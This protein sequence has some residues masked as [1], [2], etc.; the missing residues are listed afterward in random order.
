MTHAADELVALFQQGRYPEAEL[1]ARRWITALPG[2][3]FGWK[4]LGTILLQTGRHGEAIAALEEAAQRMPEDAETLGNLGQAC[5]RLGNLHLAHHRHDEAEACYRRSLGLMPDQPDGW[6]NLGLALQ[7]ANR[8]SEAEAAFRQAMRLNP[9]DPEIHAN[10]YQLLQAQ[11]RLPDA[12]A[13]LREIA[14]LQPEDATLRFELGTRLFLLECHGEAEQAF[15]EAI[16]LHP[17]HAE[18]YN[19]L[20]ILLDALQRRDEAEAAYREAI[21]LDP[22]RAEPYQNLGLILHERGQS[23]DAMACH[24]R[25]IACRPDFL[26]AHASLVHLL[27]ITCGWEEMPEASDRLLTLARAGAGEMVPFMALALPVSAMEQRALA[28]R[29][30][31]KLVS[32]YRAAA[33]AALPERQPERLAI[34]YLSADIKEHPVAHLIAELIELHDR[35][36]FAIHVYSHGRDDGHPVRQRIQAGCDRFVEL[37]GL[38]D[39]EAARRIAAD[40]IHILVDLQGFTGGARLGILAC[41]P[42]PVQAN[43]L[44]YPGTLGDARLADYL[45]GDP[46]VTPPEHAAHFA[47]SLALLPHCYQP[48]ARQRQVAARPS[49]AQAGLPESGF[50]FCSF[51]QSFKY[52]AAT[53]D[54]W[55]RLLLAVPDSLLWLLQPNPA[56]TANLRCEAAARGVDPERLIFAPRLPLPEH[57][58]RL[59]LADLALDTFPYTSH[60]TGSDALWCGVPLVTRLG[61]TFASRVGASLLHAVGLPELITGDWE[62]YFSLA[63]DLA[64]DPERLRVIRERLT[65]NRATHPLFDSAGFAR[66]LE[67]LYE[68][69]WQERGAGLIPHAG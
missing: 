27:S 46:W 22:E 14:R 24:R 42:A 13:A 8:P 36:R 57:L 26:E 30:A 23:L 1:L 59:A 63:L 65:V 32:R 40:G 29:F 44:G 45:I 6:N 43:W 25:A 69:M 47:E 2:E 35:N 66:D 11:D 4:A 58:A 31:G 34:G 61:E 39:Q 67:R 38:T 62:G 49:R 56:A 5:F 3:G 50:V 12:V 51:N 9:D 18:A 20:A 48:N 60:T 15:R 28:E 37:N 68:R 53:F 64:R 33:V 21:R 17:G 54:V 7:G 19:N 52:N 55:C 41:R 16:R 10:L